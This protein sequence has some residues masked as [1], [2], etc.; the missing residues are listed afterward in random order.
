ME[1]SCYWCDSTDGV[2][3]YTVNY[4]II[5]YE[6]LMRRRNKYKYNDGSYPSI[7]HIDGK[8]WLGNQDA[9]SNEELLIG[10]SH[11]LVCGIFLNKHFPDKFIYKQFNIKD[12]LSEDISIY[13]KEAIAYIEDAE[14][15]YIHCQKGISR[16]PSFV[17]AYLMWKSR[18]SYNDARK[19]V[20]SKRNI[21][22]PNENF[23]TQLIQFENFL[24]NNQ[25]NLI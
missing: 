2:Q 22:N 19:L 3:K 18:L 9:S 17:I 21:I 4:C 24:I 15:I 16:S 6:D 1:N 14:K 13:F 7:D 25:Y 11:I 20:K 23:E 8:I 10:F 5:C 12:D